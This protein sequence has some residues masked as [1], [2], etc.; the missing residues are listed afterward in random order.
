LCNN[1]S[2]PLY[3]LS[4]RRILGSQRHSNAF[5]RTYTRCSVSIIIHYS[6]V[7]NSLRRAPGGGPALLHNHRTS[8]LAPEGREGGL[9]V[10]T[11]SRWSHKRDSRPPRPVAR[12]GGGGGAPGGDQEPLTGGHTNGTPAPPSSPPPAAG[13]PLDPPAREGQK[14]IQHH[15][16]PG[17]SPTPVLSGLKPL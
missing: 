1:Y 8:P 5:P 15:A 14:W 3:Q 9:L 16:V 7:T 12:G 10:G 2:L 6:Y 11:K 17:W 13:S 4:Y